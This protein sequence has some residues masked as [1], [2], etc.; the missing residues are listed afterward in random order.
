MYTVTVSIT[1]SAPEQA[2]TAID[3]FARN[4]GYQATVPD[5]ENEG[6]TMDNPVTADDFAAEY[7]RLL[8]GR[9]AR[10]QAESEARVAVNAQLDPILN[11]ATVVLT[12]PE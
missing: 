11:T 3:L 9:R 6:E 5:P 7:L 2:R 8:L 4:G 10:E 12:L 1:F